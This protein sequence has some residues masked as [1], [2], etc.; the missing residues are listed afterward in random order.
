VE[1]ATSSGAATIELSSGGDGATAGLYLT[2][3]SGSGESA[4]YRMAKTSCP[5]RDGLPRPSCSSLR[6]DAGDASGDGEIRMVASEIHTDDGHLLANHI[7]VRSSTATGFQGQTIDLNS[8]IVTSGASVLEPS[9]GMTAPNDPIPTETISFNN[10]RVTPT[11]VVVASV[12]DQCNDRSGVTITTISAGTGSLVFT[13]ANFGTRA[14]GGG[15]LSADE[16]YTISWY[17]VSDTSQVF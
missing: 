15:S 6:I 13:V 14:C 12:V 7:T 9:P 1:V 17:L 8:G 16:R 4:Q 10:Y 5:N 11:S 3:S 2:S